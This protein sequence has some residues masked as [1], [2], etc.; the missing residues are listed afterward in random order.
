MHAWRRLSRH[1]QPHYKNQVRELV[2]GNEIPRT[3]AQICIIE[4]SRDV[5]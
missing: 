3:V 4:S 2:T 5:P 1:F